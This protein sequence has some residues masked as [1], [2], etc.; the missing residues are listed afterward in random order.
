MKRKSNIMIQK[1][2]L[3]TIARSLP[4][5]V[6]C[7]EATVVV[8]WHYMNKIGLNWIVDRGKS[9]QADVTDKY[10]QLKYK[11]MYSYCDDKLNRTCTPGIYVFL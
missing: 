9:F 8:L 10:V 5:N 7:L 2:F 6:K 1:C 4:Y 11:G 3:C